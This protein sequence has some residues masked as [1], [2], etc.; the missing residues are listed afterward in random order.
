LLKNAQLPGGQPVAKYSRV[1]KHTENELMK[2]TLLAAVLIAAPFATLAGQEKYVLDASHSQIVFSYS[3]G[4][5][6][7]FK[8][9]LQNKC[10]SESLR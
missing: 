4:Y 6:L 1:T 3:Q 9:L 8:K 10:V 7:K 2:S 5:L